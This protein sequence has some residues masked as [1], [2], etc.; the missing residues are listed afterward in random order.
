[1]GIVVNRRPQSCPNYGG[2]YSVTAW[3]LQ[4]FH[5]KA[6]KED[7]FES[8]IPKFLKDGI[9]F[10][11]MS[12]TKNISVKICPLENKFAFLVCALTKVILLEVSW[13]ETVCQTLHLQSQ[14]VTFLLIALY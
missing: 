3:A 2:C 14:H 9:I 6:R 1:M 12:L 5:K 7:F 10:N 8:E 11:V 4:V 13:V